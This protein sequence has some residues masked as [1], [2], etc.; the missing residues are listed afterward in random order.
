MLSFITWFAIIYL[1]VGFLRSIMTTQIFDVDTQELKKDLELADSDVEDLD[2]LRE[3]YTESK[4]K[5]LFFGSIVLPYA[6]L[7]DLFDYLRGKN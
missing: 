1:V 3:L 2:R 7:E 4:L 5:Y 6:A